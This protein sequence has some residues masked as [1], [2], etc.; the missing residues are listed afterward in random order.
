M[1][2]IAVDDSDNPAPSNMAGKTGMSNI[3]SNP[4]RTIEQANTCRLPRPNTVR[5]RVSIFDNE[6][7]SPRENSRK[8]NPSS[9]SSGSCSFSLTQLKAVGP[10]INPTHR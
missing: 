1:L 6:N 3:I 4:P 2:T 7:S 8:T 5:C 10:I 9:A